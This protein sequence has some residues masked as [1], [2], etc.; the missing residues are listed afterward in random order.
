MISLEG[1]LVKSSICPCGCPQ[2]SQFRVNLCLL[3]VNRLRQIS[4]LTVSNISG[5]DL[6]SEL[7]SLIKC[8]DFTDM[9]F[10]FLYSG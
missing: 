6:V 7:R 9:P 3:A 2:M 5:Q 4:S 8:L 10:G 1:S